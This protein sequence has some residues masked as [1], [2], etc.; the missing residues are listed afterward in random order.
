MAQSGYVGA[1]VLADVARFG[2]PSGAG[3]STGGEAFGGAIR[4]G[5]AIAERWGIDLEFTRPG[6]IERDTFFA[7]PLGVPQAV[8]F[9]GRPEGAPASGQLAIGGVFELPGPNRPFI[10]PPTTTQRYTTLTTLAWIRQPLGSRADIVYLG[11]L[12]FVRLATRTTFGIGRLASA[13]IRA[14]D[15]SYTTYGT[16]PAVGLDVRVT[17]TE[18]LRLVPGLRLLAVDESESGWL[19]RPSVGL[20]WRF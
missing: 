18:H 14:F 15:E 3:T 13:G 5:T 19:A 6:E 8:M 7:L 10:G 20:Q 17:M 16:A 1:S 12:A 2:G 4:V 9:A 11:G